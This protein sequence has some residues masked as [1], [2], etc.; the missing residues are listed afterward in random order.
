MGSRLEKE[1]LFYS[2]LSGFLDGDG[3]IAIKFEKSKTNKL[4]FRVRARV[5]FTQ[6]KSRRKVLDFIYKYI[7]SGSITEYKHNNMAEYV[8]YDQEIIKDLLI[9]I[10]PFVFVKS[11]QLKLAL[12]LIT[13]K[14]NGYNPKSLKQMFNIY[15][16]MGGLNNYPK[17]SN[18]TP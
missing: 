8:I 16:K 11:E 9:K 13:L 6:H 7:K 17:T 2:Y 12:K 14:D 3:C 5:S 1:K 18:L 15:K 4:G 10:R